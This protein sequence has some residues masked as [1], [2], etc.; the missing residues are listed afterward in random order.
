MH[1]GREKPMPSLDID[2]GSVGGVG[3]VTISD[4]FGDEA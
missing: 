4:T 1:P 2:A 3:G